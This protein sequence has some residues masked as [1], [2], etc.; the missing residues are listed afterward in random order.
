MIEK[1]K[2]LLGIAPQAKPTWEVQLQ[3]D[4]DE[5][6]TVKSGFISH[7]EAVGYTKQHLSGAWQA[8]RVRIEETAT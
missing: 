4:V 6:E 3:R 5:W 8:N 2:Q 7:S 1:I